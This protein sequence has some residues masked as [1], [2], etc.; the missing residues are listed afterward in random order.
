MKGER[1]PCGAC[2]RFD[3]AAGFCSG[4]DRPEQ[5]DGQPCPLFLER[6]SREAREAMR[7]SAELLAD[8]RRRHPSGVL[9]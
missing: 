2:A 4:H 1:Q 5:P 7:T 6:G 3:P 8:L 9:K